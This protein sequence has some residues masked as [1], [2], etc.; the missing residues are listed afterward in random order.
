[1]PKLKNLDDLEKLRESL[2]NKNKSITTTV[3]ICGGTGCQA[4]ES[5]NVV[6]ALQAELAS[7]RLDESVKVRVTGCHGF[8]E[9]GP[10]MVIDP[11]NIFY[12]RVSPDDIS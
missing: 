10:I 1:M 12:C 5:I 2:Q 9:Q 8:C 11:D 4:S 7:K 6:N 3:I